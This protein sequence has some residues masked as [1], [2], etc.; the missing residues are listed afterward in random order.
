MN[1]ISKMEKKT[2]IARVTYQSKKSKAMD[3][4]SKEGTK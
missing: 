1:L 3:Q 2:F 4:P